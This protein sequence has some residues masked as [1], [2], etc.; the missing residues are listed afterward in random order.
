MFIASEFRTGGCRVCRD[1]R[2][3]W[4]R[5][6]KLS[7]L[8]LLY[9]ISK[10]LQ[11][12]FHCLFTSFAIL[13]FD[14]FTSSV[15]GS[16]VLNSRCC[17][18]GNW[19]P[20]HDWSLTCNIVKKLSKRSNIVEMFDC[21]K[22]YMYSDRWPKMH[23]GQTSSYMGCW[24]FQHCWSNKCALLS[25]IHEL[26]RSVKTTLWSVRSVQIVKDVV[27]PLTIRL[28]YTSLLSSQGVKH[29]DDPYS[30]YRP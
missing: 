27:G 23:E 8:D 16:A 22:L 13:R 6:L 18:V 15:S 29:F 20:K 26:L 28:L 24:P 25:N 11:H 19:V 3:P 17:R 9:P 5:F 1:R 4:Q 30:L 12:S 21:K 14:V 2:L 7:I 10:A